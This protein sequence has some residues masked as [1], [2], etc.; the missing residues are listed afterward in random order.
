MAKGG[1]E[2][3]R[4]EDEVIPAAKVRQRKERVRGL[5][6]LLVGKTLEF[7]ILRESFTGELGED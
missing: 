6:R 7:E 3:I 4:I 2:A 5:E 1:R